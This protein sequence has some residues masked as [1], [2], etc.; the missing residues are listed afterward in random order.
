MVRE[1]LYDAVEQTPFSWRG[2]TRGPPSMTTAA[3][4]RLR[5]GFA[6]LVIL[7]GG[8]RLIH[9]DPLGAQADF[10]GT[11]FLAVWAAVLL[12]YG[13][14]IGR[15]RNRSPRRARFNAGVIVSICALLVYEAIWP[16]AGIPLHPGQ[17]ALI[18]AVLWIP[19]ALKLRSD[20]AMTSNSTRSRR[21]GSTARM[22]RRYRY[23]TFGERTGSRVRT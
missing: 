1:D 11:A 8:L 16:R 20:T 18:L 21:L 12:V 9:G 15:E 7:L 13:V 14:S 2:E 10:R 23:I 5:L 17:V 4:V 22:G 3:T 6:G 19:W